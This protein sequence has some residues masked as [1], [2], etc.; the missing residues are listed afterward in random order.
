MGI[1]A[2]LASV[3]AKPV[4]GFA[5]VITALVASWHGWTVHGI[6]TSR[7]THSAATQFK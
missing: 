6:C 5:F 2:A 1:R 7:A 4:M 3:P